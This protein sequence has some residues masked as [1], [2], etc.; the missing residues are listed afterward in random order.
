MSLLVWVVALGALFFIARAW[1][2]HRE[3]D[4]NVL[5]EAL[6][7]PHDGA[8]EELVWPVVGETQLNDDRSSRQEA[9]AQCSEGTHVT[10]E[11]IDGGPGGVDTA[12][13]ITE[14][15][16]IGNLRK[17]AIEKLHQLK[18]HH[19]KVDAYIGELEGGGESGRIRSATLQVYVYKD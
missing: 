8:I 18:R 14:F 1:L 10:I 17:D 4:E 15:G 13:V 9:I 11:F 7:P 6:A 12:R 19:Q 16:E 3:D 5:A 2:R